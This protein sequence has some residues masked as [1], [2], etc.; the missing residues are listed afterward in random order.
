[1]EFKSLL[2]TSFKIGTLR[3][4]NNK[5][6][7]NEWEKFMNFLSEINQKYKN[8]TCVGSVNVTA[9]NKDRKVFQYP[10]WV[11]SVSVEITFCAFLQ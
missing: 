9:F 1:M 3:M 11:S 4:L 8:I 6:D 2:S 5:I 10:I 7:E